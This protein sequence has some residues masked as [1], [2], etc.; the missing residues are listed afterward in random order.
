M[1]REFGVKDVK[2]Q[3]VF[4]MD[5]EILDGLKYVYSTEHYLYECY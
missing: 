5:K 4:T 2:V 1:L 3:E